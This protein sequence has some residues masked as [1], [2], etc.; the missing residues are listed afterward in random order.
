MTDAD[1]KALALRAVGG[2]TRPDC[3]ADSCHQGR[4]VLALAADRDALRALVR[5][6]YVHCTGLPY[7]VLQMTTDQKRRWHEVTGDEYAAEL[8]E[9]FG[10]P[11]PAPPVEETR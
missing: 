11:A 8:L 5:H 2:C 10:V 6:L 1:L 9:L 3:P 4:A 7:A